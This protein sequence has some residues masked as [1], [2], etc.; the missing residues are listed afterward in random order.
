MLG[1]YSWRRGL[2]VGN[3]ARA[4][5]SCSSSRR[6][7]TQKLKQWGL[8]KNVPTK[9]MKSALQKRARAGENEVSIKFRGTTITK[10]NMDRWQQRV[11]TFDPMSTPTAGEYTVVETQKLSQ[12]KER[13]YSV[14]DGRRISTRGPIPAAGRRSTKSSWAITSYR[15]F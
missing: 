12:L 11:P 9:V 2:M 10:E 5:F 3:G 4:E 8:F 13:R 7:Y 15:H 1:K 6:Q 14:A